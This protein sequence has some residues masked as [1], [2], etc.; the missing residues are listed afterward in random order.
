MS[1][2]VPAAVMEV[3]KLSWKIAVWVVYY[4]HLALISEVCND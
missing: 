4:T 1:V 3:P 2:D